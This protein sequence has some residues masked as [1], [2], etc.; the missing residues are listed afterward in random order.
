MVNYKNELCHHGI[1]G[2]KWGVR[3]Y[4]NEDGTL[5][6]AGKVRYGSVEKKHIS[7]SKK[8]SAIAGGVTI[9]AAATYVARHPEIVKNIGN[10][11]AMNAAMP[12]AAVVSR[13]KPV[14]RTVGEAAK[15]GLKKGMEGGTEKIVTAA[16]TGSVM[17]VGKHALDKILGT[18]VAGKVMNANN[19]KKIGSFWNYTE[20]KHKKDEDDDD[21]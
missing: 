9:A 19:K 12:H 18:D 20:P 6:D 15:S 10:R 13:I 5:T 11:S 21:D 14:A 1:K 8:V 17:L 16:V 4:R 7:T 3:R 2:M